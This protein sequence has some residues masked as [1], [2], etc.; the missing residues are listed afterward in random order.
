MNSKV[1]IFLSLLL[2]RIPVT[3]IEKMMEEINYPI[4]V[5]RLKNPLLKSYLD[6]L[7]I[8]LTG[9]EGIREV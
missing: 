6:D 2:E 3:E 7:Y 4:P 5:Y 9:E 1:K 8:R